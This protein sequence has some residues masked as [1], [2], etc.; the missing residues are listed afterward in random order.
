ME[1]IR[2]LLQAVLQEREG[3]EAAYRA[4]ERNIQERIGAIK[5]HVEERPWRG[6][7]PRSRGVQ[8]QCL[9]VPVMVGCFFSNFS[10][11]IDG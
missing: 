10:F 2:A 3:R 7:L 6:S 11:L 1:E 5:P 4:W 9:S 8:V